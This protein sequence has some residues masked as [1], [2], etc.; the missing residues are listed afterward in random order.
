MSTHDD[1]K[2][3]GAREAK[4]VDALDQGEQC[5]DAYTMPSLLGESSPLVAAAAA[6]AGSLAT[7][8]NQEMLLTNLG[9]RKLLEL[10]GYAEPQCHEDGLDALAERLGLD[11]FTCEAAEI[12]PVAALL[13][14]YVDEPYNCELTINMGPFK[15]VAKINAH[16][17]LMPEQ[18]FSIER[19]DFALTVSDPKTAISLFG[20]DDKHLNPKV[21]VGFRF[22]YDQRAEFPLT[23]FGINLPLIAGELD[24]AKSRS[25][26][27]AGVQALHVIV[28]ATTPEGAPPKLNLGLGVD[29]I[30]LAGGAGL[31]KTFV[32][33]LSSIGLIAQ[34]SCPFLFNFEGDENGFRVASASAELKGALMIGKQQSSAETTDDLSEQVAEPEVKLDYGGGFSGSAKV[35]TQY[36][37]VNAEGLNFTQTD[38]KVSA[39]VVL[40]V[41]S[42]DLYFPLHWF[43]RRVGTEREVINRVEEIG[44]AV[45]PIAMRDA[46]K[47]HGSGKT[48]F[49]SVNQCFREQATLAFAKLEA[50]IHRQVPA[51]YREIVLLHPPLV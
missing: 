33:E 15:L 34:V 41:G 42:V 11:A 49:Q 40:R 7:T 50:L 16:I 29:P 44:P 21:A 2:E 1:G 8:P 17:A 10:I 48:F 30:L 46:V 19:L 38:A 35:M 31:L 9:N 32:D 4:A 14:G 3:R 28:G 24:A 39:G 43:D 13:P 26:L 20:G 6:A 36:A 12:G 47:R 5:N 18:V 51:G 27:K 25:T 23:R 37:D 22:V 45:F